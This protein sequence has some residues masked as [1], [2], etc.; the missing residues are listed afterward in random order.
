MKAFKAGCFAA[1]VFT[2]ILAFSVY[3]ILPNTVPTHWNAAGEVD[4]WGASWEGAFLFPIM[5]IGILLIFVVI[6][7]IIVFKKNFKDFEKQYWIL[8]FVILL[9]FFL[10]YIM[11]IL[12]N[13][14]YDFNFSQILVLPMAML[15]ISI[16]ILLPSFKRNFF[17]GIRT[18]WTLADDKIWT[19]THKLGGKLFILAGFASL[20]SVP[21]PNATIWVLVVGALIT[22]IGS[23]LYSLYLFKKIG[24]NKL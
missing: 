5:M 22:G 19:K 17:V 15:F 16:G 24:K 1:V 12:P 20:I 6:P 10:F 14:G 21:F 9:F 23:M 4:G 13:F 18:P 3:S 11:T 7:K 8:A 2:V